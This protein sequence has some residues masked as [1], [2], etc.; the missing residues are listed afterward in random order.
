MNHVATFA[1]NLVRT[2]HISEQQI[3]YKDISRILFETNI[4][5]VKFNANDIIPLFKKQTGFK[6][7]LISDTETRTIQDNVKEFMAL[8]PTDKVLSI[9]LD[10]LANDPEFQEAF[11]YIQSEEFPNIHQFVQYL[12]NYKKVS[13]FMCMFLKHKSDRDNICSVSTGV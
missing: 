13:A 6:K 7:Y 2:R 8:V 1:E 3:S 10:Y 4:L 9:T 5:H 12:K 11:G